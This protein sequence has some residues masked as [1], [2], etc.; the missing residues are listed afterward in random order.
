MLTTLRRLFSLF[1]LAQ[2][3]AA[4]EPTTQPYI[5]TAP[6]GAE[7]NAEGKAVESEAL[8]RAFA[9]ALGKYVSGCKLQGDPLPEG[10]DRPDFV[11]R[12]MD[13]LRRRHSKF[14]LLS[15]TEERGLLPG[16]EHAKVARET[17]EEKSKLRRPVSGLT[18]HLLIRFQRGELQGVDLEL[19][20]RLLAIEII[21]GVESP[22]PVE[23]LRF[24][25]DTAGVL[26]ALL[27]SASQLGPPLREAA[28]LPH[29]GPVQIE[30][31]DQTP[32]GPVVNLLNRCQ[33]EGLGR[34]E[35][36]LPRGRKATVDLAVTPA[37]M[38]EAGRQLTIEI[39]PHGAM[40]L[41]GAAVRAADLRRE[42][43]RFAQQ[44]PKPVP[45][46]KTERPTPTFFLAGCLEILAKLELQPVAF[47][48]AGQFTAIRPRPVGSMPAEEAILSAAQ[49]AAPRQLNEAA[50]EL[51]KLYR[52][53]L[54][55][56]V[57]REQEAALGLVTLLK[58]ARGALPKAML[59]AGVQLEVPELQKFSAADLADRSIAELFEIAAKQEAA[60]V[61]AYRLI[62]AITLSKTQRVS[63]QDAC[64]ATKLLAP[65]RPKADAKL[66][67][68]AVED[69]NGLH[70][71]V[72]ELRKLLAEFQAQATDCRRRLTLAD[73]IVRLQPELVWEEGGKSYEPPEAADT[74]WGVHAG[75]VVL[76][77]ELGLKKALDM[78]QVAP[79]PGRKVFRIA[80]KETSLMFVNH[81]QIIGPFVND[82]RETVDQKHPPE[83]VVDLDCI[84]AGKGGKPLR[85][86]T[87]DSQEM[88]VVPRNPLDYAVWYA[89]TELQ[90]DADREVY[91]FF[92]ADDYGKVWLNGK[93]IWSSGKTPHPWI[94]DRGSAKVCLNKGV[95]QML[96]KFENAWGRTG[97]SV[98]VVL[99]QDEKPAPTTR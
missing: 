80:G 4:A 10:Y 68:A 5:R 37:Q 71:L 74:R 67:D 31:G 44:H 88:P 11:D 70:A 87:L 47:A 64:E 41:N 59:M 98:I 6:P 93:R 30:A 19:A 61:A 55:A 62:Q 78:G 14:F 42:L 45:L 39:D 43:T 85:W 50:K 46:V 69:F 66:L 17:L 99:P 82:R 79:R 28:K 96:V 36:L 8:K 18:R 33:F 76:P 92:G 20:A 24:Q 83:A 21:A 58:E 15:P 25:V 35:L 89:W 40:Q 22:R 53:E 60:T 56:G 23:H 52:N 73:G 95:N 54:A 12:Q 26:Y 91:M 94:P 9:A 2:V 63:F 3:A 65:E 7:A 29:P 86:E 81:W 34:V 49:N 1:L 48:G 75:P 32:A 84:Y 13:S 51:T 38:W 77:D 72:T 16:G 90:S 57:L 27:P 97:F